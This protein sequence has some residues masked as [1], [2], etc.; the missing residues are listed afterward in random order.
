MLY[1]VG[2]LDKLA[3]S[4]GVNRYPFAV[5]IMAVQARLDDA[6]EP[7]VMEASGLRR[8]HSSDGWEP[9]NEADLKP[10]VGAPARRRP[11]NIGAGY[12][13]EAASKMPLGRPIALTTVAPR[14]THSS[15][16]K[17]LAARPFAA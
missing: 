12:G 13:Y 9:T 5:K 2:G 17:R 6:S 15:A 1:H 10:S 8:G 11:L 7:A 3:A 14:S 16:L 4:T